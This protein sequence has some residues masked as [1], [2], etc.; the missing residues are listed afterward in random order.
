MSSIPNLG[1]EFLP[2]RE[3][4][5]YLSRGEA[6][7]QRDMLTRPSFLPHG[8]HPSF[9]QVT[10]F[11]ASV[12]SFI[13]MVHKPPVLTTSRGHVFPG[14]AYKNKNLS[15][16]LVNLSSVKFNSYTPKR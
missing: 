10:C 12:L 15:F 1:T 14:A 4:D 11:P 7:H 8:L 13:K 3:A 16:P 5:S 2:P 6:R 9:L